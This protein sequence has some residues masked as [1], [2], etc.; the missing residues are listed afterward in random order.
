MTFNTEMPVPSDSINE[1]MYMAVI[2][3]DRSGLIL[4][5]MMKNDELLRGNDELIGAVR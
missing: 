2:Q 1:G 4:S 5:T 3:V